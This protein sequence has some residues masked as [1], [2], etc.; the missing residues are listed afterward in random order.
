MYLFSRLILPQM[1]TTCAGISLKVSSRPLL[2]AEKLP[3]FAGSFLLGSRFAACLLDVQK[4]GKVF[5]KTG[6]SCECATLFLEDT[7]RKL[8]QKDTCSKQQY[9]QEPRR[10]SNLNVHQEMDGWRC[11]I[12]TQME[13]CSAIKKNGIMPFA[14]TWTD[15]RLKCFDSIFAAFLNCS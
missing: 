6:S 15:Q 10:G 11:G 8:F 12:N 4:V 1:T 9:L 3:E 13:C 14:A 7:W 5:E 2:D